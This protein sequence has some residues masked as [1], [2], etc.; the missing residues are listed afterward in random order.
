MK[1][2]LAS[3]TRVLALLSSWVYLAGLAVASDTARPKVNER[4]AED[5][6]KREGQAEDSRVVARLPSPGGV[7]L[8]FSRD[9]SRLL[10]AGSDQAWVWDAK[11]FRPIAGPLRH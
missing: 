6:P 7:D 8:A 4:N 5:L 9:G 3:R 10:T 11:T 2:V 1:T